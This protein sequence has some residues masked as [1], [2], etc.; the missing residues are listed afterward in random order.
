MSQSWLRCSNI[1]SKSTELP[2]AKHKT[3][4]N[5]PRL[6]ASLI[7]VT[8]N[9][10]KA[11]PK[12]KESPPEISSLVTCTIAATLWKSTS[13]AVISSVKSRAQV[14]ICTHRWTRWR[15]TQQCSHPP[16]TR[17]T[18]Q[19]AAL[20]SVI[21]MARPTNESDYSKQSK[22][23]IIKNKPGKSLWR[24]SR[25]LLSILIVCAHLSSHLRH[26]RRILTMRQWIRLASYCRLWPS[27]S[28]IL[29]KGWLRVSLEAIGSVC[30]AA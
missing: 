21:K 5:Q 27:Y 11:P 9:L 20:D 24:L 30:K 13:A 16:W 3:S 15:S 6:R 4:T 8:C 18:K 23:L 14:S 26:R 7:R 19:K 29:A 17:S 2:P 25:L 10:Y 1:S 28:L 12:I 22:P